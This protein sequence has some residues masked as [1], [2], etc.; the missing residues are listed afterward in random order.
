MIKSFLLLFFITTYFGASSQS[1]QSFLL[2][3]AC[4]A[5]QILSKTIDA[6]GGKSNLDSLKVL[7]REMWGIGSEESQQYKPYLN[8]DGLP[9]VI[10]HPYHHTILDFAKQRGLSFANDTGCSIHFVLT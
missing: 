4:K 2:E 10:S 9:G 5:M 8:N 1:Q 7:K 6:M 3:N